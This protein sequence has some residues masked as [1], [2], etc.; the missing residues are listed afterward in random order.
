[1]NARSWFVVGC[2]A[3]VLPAFG[4][5]APVMKEGQVSENA[6]IDALTPA[7]PVRTRSIRVMRDDE[8]AGPAARPSANLLITFERNSSALTESAKRALDVVGNAM[9]SDKLGSFRFAIEGY[10]DPRGVSATNLKLSQ[11]R[12]ESVR[13]YLVRGKHIDPAR[14]EPIG[15]GDRELMNKVN[16]IAPENRRV[17]IVNISK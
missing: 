3:M 8:P 14:L 2:M 1:M 12:A 16:P 7:Q 4:Q 9:A 17:T 15:K 10:A 11:A 6:L 13:D 5:Q